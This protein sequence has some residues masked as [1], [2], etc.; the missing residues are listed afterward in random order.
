M[1][2]HAIVRLVA[3]CL[4]LYVACNDLKADE[5]AP[6]QLSDVESSEQTALAALQSAD[7]TVRYF[8]D[9]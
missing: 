6:T 2:T 9:D 5:E 1:K 4:L 3:V 8:G 7:I